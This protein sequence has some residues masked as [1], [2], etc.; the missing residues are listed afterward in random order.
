MLPAEIVPRNEDSLHCDVMGQRL[1]MGIGQP[2]KSSALH[3]NRQIE[4]F[5][6]RRAN[7][8]RI[9]IAKANNFI[10]SYYLDWRIAIG[11]NGRKGVKDRDG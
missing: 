2:C 11:I 9:R 6:V 4:P 10:G 1:R 7:L 5:N 3:S 8:G